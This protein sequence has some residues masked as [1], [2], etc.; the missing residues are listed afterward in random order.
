MTET[1]MQA[2]VLHDIGAE[3]TVESVALPQ[4]RPDEILVRVEASNVVQ[5][6]RNVLKAAGEDSPMSYPTLPAIF[7]LDNAGTVE[8]CGTIT[9]GFSEGDRVYVNPGISCGGCEACRKGDPLHCQRYALRGYFG[10]SKDSQQTLDNFPQG[11]FAQFMSVSQ[12]QLVKLPDGLDFDTASRLGY[13]GTAFRALRL[14]ECGPGSVVVVNG[15]TGTLGLGV[16][17]I[18]VA[19]GA[20]KVLGTARDAELLARVK[21]LADGDR[22]E[23]LELG[24]R[25]VDEWVKEKTG[26]QGADIAIDALGQGAPTDPMQQAMRSLKRGGTLV[27][28]GAVEGDLPVDLMWMMSNCIRILGSTWFTTKESQELADMIGTGILDLSFFETETFPLTA[29]NEA[30]SDTSERS[31]GFSNFVLR[32]N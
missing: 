20:A 9:S 6:L 15:V 5:N 12:A 19:L 11:G 2:A 1:T 24:T 13:L 22:I 14:A 26:D 4:V 27:N 23:V 16:A 29:V 7:G 8:R 3:M 25:P 17:V 30:I 32:P 10:I 21:A 18:A 28:I 31:G